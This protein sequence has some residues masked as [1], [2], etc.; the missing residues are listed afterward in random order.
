[1]V[2]LLTKDR[3]TGKIGRIG[4]SGRCCVIFLAPVVASNQRP[5]FRAS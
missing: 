1:M 2:V 4:C 5:D 3:W